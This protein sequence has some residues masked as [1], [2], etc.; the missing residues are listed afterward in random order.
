MVIVGDLFAGG[1]LDR[2]TVLQRGWLAV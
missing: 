2:S 1:N